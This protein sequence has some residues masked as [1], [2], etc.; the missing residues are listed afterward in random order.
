MISDNAVMAGRIVIERIEFRGRCGVTSEER[1]RPQPLAVDLELDCEMAQAGVSDD[2]RQT[3]DYAAVVHRIVETGTG[4]ETQL[5][6]TMA[7]ELLLVIFHEFQVNRIQLWLRKLSPPITCVTR[8]VGITI[9]RTRLEQQMLRACPQPATFLAQQL[10]R[11]PK[12]TVLD[13]AAGRGRH[14]LFLSSLGYQ[15]EAID[16]DAEAL[17]QLL[18]TARSQ[19]LAGVTTRTLDLEPPPPHAPSLGRAR[20]DAILVFFYLNRPLFP[21]LRDALKPGGVLL[22][23]TFLIENHV[24]HHHPK[25]QEFCLAQG[26]LL[27]L[28]SGLRVLHYD[29][30]PH[31]GAHGGESMYTAQL[32]AQKPIH[33][34]PTV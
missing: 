11:L 21:H 18:T 6:E 3:V 29:E 23:E 5:L 32:V 33:S 31:E 1:A 2:L 17:A 15:V 22:Y 28:T 34:G 20:Y 19:N 10:H 24:Q 27:D 12:G 30:G 13:V 7:E 16:R 4:R 9:E 14:T 8:S 25:R 26:E